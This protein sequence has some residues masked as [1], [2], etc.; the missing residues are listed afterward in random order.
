MMFIS[1]FLDGLILK[2]QD[3]IALILLMLIFFLSLFGPLYLI[4]K[5]YE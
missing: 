2:R 3:Q 5:R 1:P 4:G